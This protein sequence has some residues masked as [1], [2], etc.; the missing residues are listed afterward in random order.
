MRGLLRQPAPSS[1]PNAPIGTCLAS[2]NPIVPAE[3]VQLMNTRDVL[4]GAGIGAAIAFLLDPNRGNYRR[5]LVRDKMTRAARLTRDGV[6]ATARDMSNRARGMA[7]ATRG[8]FSR[9]SVNDE[10]LVE[11]VRAKLGRACSHPRAIDVY[12]RNGEITLSGPI[13]SSEVTGLLSVISSVRGVRNV[14]NY[15]QA[16]DSGEDIPSLQGEGRLAEPSWNL[17][18]RDWAPATRALVT[19]SIVAGVGLAAYARR[20]SQHAATA[21]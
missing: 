11:R 18:Q 13:L 14:R 4:T 21:A 15:M 1:S 6:D 17:L 12:A 16:H 5:A 7:A 3:E 8:R 10:K 19:A 2:N 9:G 20:G